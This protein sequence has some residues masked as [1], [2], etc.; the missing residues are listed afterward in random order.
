[1]CAN[2]KK[3]ANRQRG[4]HDRISIAAVAVRPLR[5]APLADPTH[6]FPSPHFC[7]KPLPQALRDTPLCYAFFHLPSL[8][9]GLEG[10]HCQDAIGVGRCKRDSHTAWTRCMGRHGGK[11]TPLFIRVEGCAEYV[12]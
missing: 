1:M 6:L 9:V 7:H 2:G 8:G 3:V 10:P 4:A 5:F 12:F 11:T